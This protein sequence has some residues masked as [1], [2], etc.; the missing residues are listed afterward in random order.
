MPKVQTVYFGIAGDHY[1]S[2]DQPSCA[3]NGRNLFVE[4]HRGQDDDDSPTLNYRIAMLRDASL[5]W[6]DLDAN[7][8][9][10]PSFAH[11]Q[12]PSVTL[13][14]GNVA[15]EAHDDKNGKLFY[16]VLSLAVGGK[17]LTGA[18]PA[19]LGTQDN[20]SSDPSVSINDTNVL[21]EVHKSGSDLR[22]RLGKLS[23]TSVTW[24]ADA[25]FLAE[26]GEQ[27]SVWINDQGRLVAVYQKNEKLFYLTGTYMKASNDGTTPATI[28]WVGP[29]EY[30]GGIRPSVVLTGANQVF[31]VH[32]TVNDGALARVFQRVGTLD[33]DTITWHDWLSLS[34]ESYQFDQGKS[35]QITTNGRVAV[36]V[37][38]SEEA[39]NFNLFATASV[40]VDRANWMSDN[41]TSL[42][43]KMLSQ[44]VMP[45]SHDAGQYTDTV[46]TAATQTQTLSI[47]QQLT[48]G[49]RWFDLRPYDDDG[50]IK[51]HH[52][53]QVGVTLQEVLDQIHAFMTSHRELVFL[54][55]SHYGQPPDTEGIPDT[56]WSADAFDRMVTM[57]R[58]NQGLQ[59]W[60][61]TGA[62][63]QRL[64]ETPLRRFIGSGKGS[65][66]V[67]ADTDTQRPGNVD[68]LPSPATPSTR[69][70][71]HYR[72]W[73]APSPEQGDLTV[74]DVYAN[75]TVFADMVNGTSS[76]ADN[77]DALARNGTPLPR[78][79]YRKFDIFDNFCRNGDPRVRCDFFLLS[80]TLTP[81]TGVVEASKPANRNLVDFLALR[82]DQ[83]NKR[84]NILY[85]D[86]VQDS[87]SIDVAYVRNGLRT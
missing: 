12:N 79:Q 87:R 41:L 67:V 4:I 50:T 21:V 1:D 44:L 28:T 37:H 25:S 81:L 58:S 53:I 26:N 73:Y 20:K 51:I 34:K 80:W 47:G 36:H 43:S 35:P 8:K 16:S 55:L 15:I 52:D 82:P 30:E 10:P 49:V 64:G 85:T 17:T 60:L 61:V 84:F 59:E 23:G 65:V 66:V 38:R 39:L 14:D 31:E 45:G 48:Y 24:D 62:L 78:G 69:G 2:G 32:Q 29:T 13:T 19:D 33:G 56:T 42:G 72:D 83:P 7:G 74:F 11:G 76:D 54:K 6:R 22:W 9:T 77:P 86:V 63:P 70:I 27:P 71:Y 68:Y 75:T 5:M 3:L 40:V 46:E 18:A 57:I